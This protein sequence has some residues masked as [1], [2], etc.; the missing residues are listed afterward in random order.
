MEHLTIPLAPR[1]LHLLLGLGILLSCDMALACSSEDRRELAIM[2]YTSE[3]IDAQC[4]SGGNPFVTPSMPIATICSTRA[5]SC[6]MGQRIPV[7]SQCWCPTRNGSAV[8][9]VAR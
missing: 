2:G 7:G 6:Y 1:V 3:Q 9:G 4:G 5:G 8:A